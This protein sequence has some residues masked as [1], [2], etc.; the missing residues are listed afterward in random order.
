M[1]A[2]RALTL[3]IPHIHTHPSTNLFVSSYTVS[4]MQ[5]YEVHV[6]FP[7]TR[8][9]VQKRFSEFHEFKRRISPTQPS[10]QSDVLPPFP[11]K[12]W[13]AMNKVVIERRRASLEAWL[14]AL[15]K[16]PGCL[17]KVMFFLDIP[18]AWTDFAGKVTSFPDLTDSEQMVYEFIAQLAA[19]PNHKLRAI[20]RF[21]NKFFDERRRL[22]SECLSELLAVLMP[23]SGE[24]LVG[25]RALNVIAK[26]ISPVHYRDHRMTVQ[27][28]LFQNVNLVQA[29]QLQRHLTQESSSSF[30]GARE[31]SIVFYEY[32]HRTSQGDKFASILN[33]SEEACHMFLLNRTGTYKLNLSQSIMGLSEEWHGLEADSD[34]TW[35]KY[36][37]VARKLTFNSIVIVS[38]PFCVCLDNVLHPEKRM[39]W[40]YILGEGSVHED[41]ERDCIEVQKGVIAGQK[42]M[43]AMRRR[44]TQLSEDCCQVSF[45]SV[46]YAGCVM[47][48]GYMWTDDI[49]YSY[50]IKRTTRL[51]DQPSSLF[52][53]CP[54]VSSKRYS[55]VKF[56]LDCK[57]PFS[58][59]MLCQLQADSS[60]FTQALKSFKACVEDEP[61]MT[62]PKSRSC[63][64][65]P[66]NSPSLVCAF[67]AKLLPRTPSSIIG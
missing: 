1:T 43:T 10:T 28:L 55:K 63:L 24:T 62:L 45:E 11:A 56:T 29:M 2:T 13:L 60:C 57:P 21:D 65:L 31:V 48:P 59:A 27:A 16:Q 23:I 26:L 64:D 50:T 6:Q 47:P 51:E 19:G 53:S 37:L 25:P 61:I 44:V 35:L 3:S 34:L 5:S 36:K 38:S 42:F 46:E 49:K 20:E 66:I 17:T 12:T 22:R 30:Q 9:V 18:Q 15:T 58:T 41:N 67:E 40:Q 39:E 52:A 33:Y 54:P 8:H 4:S 14:V 7:S 32:L